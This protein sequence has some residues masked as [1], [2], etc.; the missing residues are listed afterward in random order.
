MVMRPAHLSA[1][2]EIVYNVGKVC[3]GMHVARPLMFCTFGAT[4]EARVGMVV[5]KLI[6]RPLTLWAGQ[7]LLGHVPGPILCQFRMRVPDL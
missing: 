1:I 5:G 2:F 6:L 4:I 3:P 7:F